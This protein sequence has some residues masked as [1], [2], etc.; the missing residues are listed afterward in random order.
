MLQEYDENDLESDYQGQIRHYLNEVNGE[1][2]N[3][4]GKISNLIDEIKISAEF[5]KMIETSQQG[6][7]NNDPDT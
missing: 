7:V 4:N 6:F 1:I 3:M 2:D 5:S